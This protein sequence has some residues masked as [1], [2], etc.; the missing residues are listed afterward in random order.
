TFS[1]N[2]LFRETRFS[3]HDRLDDANRLSVGISSQFIDNEDGNKL[4]S[5]SIGQIYY[6]RDRKVRLVPG[7]PALDDSGSP[8]AADLTFTPDRHFSLWSNIVWD[9]YSGNTNSGNVLAGYT[10]DNGTIFNL[11]YAYNLPL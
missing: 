3:G 4:L 5:M 1:Y 2:Q 8:I 10:L 7:A 9:P 6:F 11:G